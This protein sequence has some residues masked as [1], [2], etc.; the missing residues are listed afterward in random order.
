MIRGSCATMEKPVSGSFVGIVGVPVGRTVAVTDVGIGTEE[1][2]RGVPV[3][4]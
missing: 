1:S 3:Y 2:G 4:G